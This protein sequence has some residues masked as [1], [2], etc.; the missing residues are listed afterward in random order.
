MMVRKYSRYVQIV[1]Y[2]TRLMF[3]AVHNIPKY[4]TELLAIWRSR[5]CCTSLS[6]LQLSS[7]MGLSCY[8]ESRQLPP[9]HHLEMMV[10][11]KFPLSGNQI[12]KCHSANFLLGMLPALFRLHQWT[13]DEKS[14]YIEVVQGAIFMEQNMRFWLAI[15]SVFIEKTNHRFTG[16]ALPS[17]R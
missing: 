10:E 2:L 1:M 15:G 8:N 9:L 14:H 3:T 13:Y 17:F 16:G 7:N 6:W 11:Q 5:S 12:P 4:N